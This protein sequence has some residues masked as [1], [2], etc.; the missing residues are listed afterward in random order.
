MYPSFTGYISPVPDL[1]SIT[2]KGE[3][4]DD[5]IPYTF[6]S[7]ISGS[8]SVSFQLPCNGLPSPGKTAYLIGR[9]DSIV[10]DRQYFVVK[11]HGIFQA[12]LK[13]LFHPQYA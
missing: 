1:P 8:T 6:S 2:L 5:P 3:A 10:S 11:Y 13:L 9:I 7:V 4:N 12:F